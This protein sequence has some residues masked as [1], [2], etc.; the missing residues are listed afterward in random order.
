MEKQI[1]KKL[2]G[3][4]LLG[5]DCFNI[6]RLIQAAHI[7]QENFEF[8]EVK[9]LTS[10]SSD[11]QDI[12]MIDPITSVEEYSKFILEKL[13]DYVDTPHVLLIQYDGF[14]LN[15]EAWSDEFLQ[16]DYIGAPWLVR[17]MSVNRFGFPKEWLGQL[18]VGNGGFSLRS[19]KLLSLCSKLTKESFFKKYHPEDLVISV[20]DR[21]LLEEQGIMFAPVPLAKQFSYEALNN[22]DY[23]WEDQFGFHGLTWTDISK[24]T[25]E[26]PEYK[27]DN[28]LRSPDKKHKYL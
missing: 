8:E 14:I 18:V 21:K 6:E 20:Y 26:H 10:I 13:D 24:W 5:I 7:C 22:N 17:D 9:L 19:K 15:S 2:K 16:Y 3:V 11:H 12:V 1:M 23:S 4:T 27:I 28:T 25:R